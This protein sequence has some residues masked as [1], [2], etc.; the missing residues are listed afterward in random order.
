MNFNKQ[1]MAIVSYKRGFE[2]GSTIRQLI[3]LHSVLGAVSFALFPALFSAGV[4]TIQSD[5]KLLAAVML[6]TLSLIV[7]V[8]LFLFFFIC[9]DE[10][11]ILWLAHITSP[12]RALEFLAVA[13]PTVGLLCLLAFYSIAAL[14]TAIFA[15]VVV[16]FLGMKT[17][18]SAC[19]IWKRKHEARLK[20]IQSDDLRQLNELDAYEFTTK[21]SSKNKWKYK[22]NI[23]TEN[24]QTKT[25]GWLTLEQRACKGDYIDWEGD[26]PDTYIILKVSHSKSE[27]TLVC[28]KTQDQP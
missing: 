25:L 28:K 11:E 17:F 2:D 15:T 10:P 19:A 5:W 13:A 22:I 27:S 14:I 23:I 9:S 20:A 4:A 18:Q 8:V 7:N 3:F 6:F 26:D 12:Y 16:G 24:G 1:R 21:D